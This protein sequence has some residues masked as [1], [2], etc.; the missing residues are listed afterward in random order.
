MTRP[1]LDSKTVLVTGGASGIGRA[2]V[3]LFVDAG[4]RVVAVDR[5]TERL[6]ALSLEQPGVI[7]NDADLSSIAGVEEAIAAA[8]GV[9]HVLC[10]NAAVTDHLALLD[11]ITDEAWEQNLLVN[12]TAPFRL[13]QRALPLMLKQNGGVI[14]NTAS[15][16]GL[17][18]GRGGI[19]YT[20]S[21]T[22]LIGMTMNIAATFGNRGIRCNAICPGPTG[23]AMRGLAPS[24]RGAAIRSRDRGKPAPA[25]HEQIA[26][27]AVYLASDD[28]KRIN[29]VA[30]PVDGGWIAY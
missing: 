2:M 4:A 21:K 17:R 18:G 20:A 3:D 25:T 12:L 9:L 26:V 7:C 29:G 27:V 6:H 22:G 19:A 23:N 11:E 24:S 1:D 16:A 5:D 15:T 10:N 14:I 8:D 28:A 13:C 30:L